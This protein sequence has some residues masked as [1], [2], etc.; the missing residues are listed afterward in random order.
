MSVDS[1]TRPKPFQ[2]IFNTAAMA[3]SVAA[4][5]YVYHANIQGIP[6]DSNPVRLGVTACIFFLMNTIPIAG[7]IGIT[8]KKSLTRIWYDC[9]FWCFPYYLGGASIA[10]IISVFTRQMHWE[11]SLVLIP[12]IYFIHR[13]YRMYLDRLERRESG[14]SRRWPACTCAPS[15]RWRW[16]SKPRTTPRT[17]TCAA[18]ASTPW[19]S[20]RRWGCLRPEMEALRAAALLHDI[21]KLA[22][23]E[24]IISKP[25]RLTPEEFEKM[26]I[27][28]VVGAEILE[29]VAVPL[30]GGAD[31]ARA[32]REVGRHR[33]SRRP[34]GRGDSLSARA[35]WRR[36]I[37][38]MRW[39][40]TA[41]T[42]RA[43]PLDEA[44]EAGRGQSGKS[45][46]SRG[47]RGASAGRT[48]NWKQ[49][50]QAQTRAGERGYPQASRIVRWTAARRRLRKR[51]PANGRAGKRI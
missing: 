20:A 9:Y 28:P 8:E 37:A 38:W 13:S 16:P 23:P 24:H 7:A 19:K 22:V 3:L 35:F 49:M 51:Q 43:L 41:S 36:W 42:A 50:A 44:M 46:R 15:K 5:Y 45:L 32:S 31:R 26:K 29:R 21:G 25:G 17:S 12:V 34:E 2:V 6:S 11:A 47:G 4:S 39:P 48:G 40:P 14:T 1:K 27:H 18:C 30:S 33:L 10:W